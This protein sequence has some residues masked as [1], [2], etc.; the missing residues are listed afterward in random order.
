MFVCLQTYFPQQ[1]TNHFAIQFGRSPRVEPSAHLDFLLIFLISYM[2]TA[3]N[4]Y[5][6]AIQRRGKGNK[7]SAVLLS[8]ANDL[9]SRLQHMDWQQGNRVL[10]R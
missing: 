6:P 7:R 3:I 2:I 4:L 9:Q 10:K 1:M 8:A 5:S